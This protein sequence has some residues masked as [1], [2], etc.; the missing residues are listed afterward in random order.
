MTWGLLV[1]ENVGKGSKE[2]WVKKGLK[3]SDQGPWAF[4]A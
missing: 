1:I 4:H 2:D 3:G